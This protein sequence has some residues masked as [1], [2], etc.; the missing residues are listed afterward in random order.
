MQDLQGVQE[1]C[2]HAIEEALGSEYQLRE[3]KWSEAIAVGN[4]CFVEA[5][6]D[7]LGVKAKGRRV[8]GEDEAYE[9]REP[10]APYGGDF[11][12]KNS[13]LRLNNTYFWNVYP[14]I[15]IR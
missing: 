11:T 15:L 14:D 12:P 10:A 4:K 1:T 7:L 13:S 3:S 2:R 8:L 9:V 5:T 6:K